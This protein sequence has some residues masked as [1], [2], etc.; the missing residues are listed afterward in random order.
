MRRSAASFLPPDKL[1]LLRA[2]FAHGGKLIQYHGWADPDI[3]PL[4]SVD[5]YLSVARTVGGARSAIFTLARGRYAG[6]QSPMR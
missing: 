6:S 1:L 4:S 2:F 3:S 5:Y